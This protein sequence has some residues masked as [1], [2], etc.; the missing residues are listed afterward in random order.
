MTTRFEF[1]TQGLDELTDRLNRGPA[2]LRITLNEGLREIGKLF[3]PAKGTGPLAAATPRRGGKLARST[4]FQIGGGPANQFLVISQPARSLEEYGGFP[5][6]V[7]VRDGTRAHEILPRL[8]RVLRF[9]IDGSVV[10]AARVKHPGTK[11]NPY[12]LR[13]FRQL[14][15]Q[16]Q[17]IIAKIGRSLT[18]F[19]AGKGS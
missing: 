17:E 15:P 8:K 19:L 5:Y 9:E 7:F 2:R 18:A 6:G 1:E 13:V 14:Q 11:P 10:F 3:V 16:V 12:H 4:F